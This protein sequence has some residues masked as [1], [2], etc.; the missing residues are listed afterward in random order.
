MKKILIGALV[1][2][3]I[4]FAWSAVSWMALGIHTNSFKYSENQDKIMEVITQNITE[5]GHYV[6]PYA[7]PNTTSREEMEKVQADMIGKPYATVTFHKEVKD[8]MGMN[9]G[10]GFVYNFIAVMMMA[11]VLW[12]GRSGMPSMAQRCMAAFA[13]VIFMVFQNHLLDGMWMEVPM[14]VMMPEIIDTVAGL[15]LTSV[16][17]AFYVKE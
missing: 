14:H 13:F 2:A 8:N 3:I 6:M 11:L 9:M 10:V 17:L 7:N 4:V 16:W 12:Y 5:D 15:G 1:G